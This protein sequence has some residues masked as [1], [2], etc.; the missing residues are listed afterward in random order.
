MKKFDR[1]DF[2]S[3]FDK[4]LKKAPLKIRIAFEKR[5][6]LFLT[7]PFNS[8]LKNH[9]LTGKLKNYRSIN[10]TGDWRAL[11][12]TNKIDKENV[13]LFEALG[14]HSQLYK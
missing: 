7:D 12:S 11:Y 2:S 9:Q 13:V 10:I 4:Q 3:T 6:E 14:T 5:I 8:Q 1:I